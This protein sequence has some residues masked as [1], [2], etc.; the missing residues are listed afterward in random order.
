MIDTTIDSKALIKAL[1]TFPKNI[2][3][4]VVKGALRASAKQTLKE[5]KATS[6]LRYGN[7]KKSWS[8]VARKQR[9]SNLIKVTITNKNKKYNGFYA[10]FIEYGTSKIPPEP[11]MR[12][13]LIKTAPECVN[14][15]RE[16][17]KLRIDKEILKAK[18]L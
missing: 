8:I 14:Q 6:P 9:V 4:N 1:K 15:A 12:P 13:A 5:L 3:K 11:F 18:G 10:N 16:Y 17:L 2:Q 7:L